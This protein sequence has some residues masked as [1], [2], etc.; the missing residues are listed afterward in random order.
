MLFEKQK[1][2]IIK[3]RKWKRNPPKPCC[4]LP[5]GRFS[6]S[7]WKALLQA[8]LIIYW[9]KHTC[10]RDCWAFLELQRDLTAPALACWKECLAWSSL[11]LSWIPLSNPTSPWS[12]PLS[13]SLSPECRSQESWL[14]HGLRSW[15]QLPWGL[16]WVAN[17][18]KSEPC[19]RMEVP[20]LHKILHR[21]QVIQTPEHLQF[22]L[23]QRFSA[24]DGFALPPWTV[25]NV[26]RHDDIMDCHK[27]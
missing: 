21:T 9:R 12:S 14:K 18:W 26:W 19:G 25:G 27:W 23:A 22:P 6:R 4:Q 20:W 3:H 24:G 17:F 10:L 2:K 5:S 11:W 8:Q 7:I 13:F 16:D 1:K 15:R